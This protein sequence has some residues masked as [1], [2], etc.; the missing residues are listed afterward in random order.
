VKRAVFLD[1]DG[2][3]NRALLVD[4]LPKPPS[5]LEEVEILPDVAEA[6]HILKKHAFLPVVVTNQPDVARGE[7]T[8]SQVEEINAYIG[9][10]TKIKYFYTCFHDD[11]D[12]CGCR[13]PLPGLI[14]LAASDLGLLVEESYMVG[15]R[16]RDIGAGQ[17]AGC[18]SFFIDYSYPEQSPKNPFTRV[19]SLLD[20]AILITGE[21][22]GTKLG[23]TQG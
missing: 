3:L 11:A 1:R 9:E 13:K 23:I 20:A 22:Y 6:I 7:K 2:V 5:C 18:Q 12:L 14:H 19:L 16:W 17:E 15:D 10:A 8:R 4:G 21:N